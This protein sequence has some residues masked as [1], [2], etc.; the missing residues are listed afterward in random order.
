MGST[1]MKTFT[2]SQV[3]PGRPDPAEKLPKIIEGKRKKMLMKGM[4]GRGKK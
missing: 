2:K 4:R 1:K 3:K